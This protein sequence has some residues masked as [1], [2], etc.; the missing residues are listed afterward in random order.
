MLFRA[1]SVM[2]RRDFASLTAHFS[3]QAI[4]VVGMLIAAGITTA[5][6]LLEFKFD[7]FLRYAQMLLVKAGILIGLF[8]FAVINKVVLA[9]RIAVDEK[10]IT[11]IRRSMLAEIGLFAAVFVATAWLTTNYSPHTADGAPHQ[12]HEQVQINGPITIIG[13]WAPAMFPGAQTAAGY[14]VIVNRQSVEDRLL[15]ASSPWAEQVTLHATSNAGTISKMDDLKFLAIPP[16][17]RI[18]IEPGAYHLMF[19]GLYAPFVEGD[20]IPVS[21]HFANAGNVNVILKVHRFGD[22]AESH[23]H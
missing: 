1:S 13:P 21:L 2:D 5:A 22:A 4:W 12:Q 23:Q 6:L 10:A 11:L 7:P 17:Q 20:D 14:M 18:A 8:V 19:T 9:P 3:S 16:G 15:S